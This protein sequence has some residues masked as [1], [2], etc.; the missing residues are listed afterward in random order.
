MI[1]NCQ[2]VSHNQYIR[3]QLSRKK[4]IKIPL[5][6]F[7]V[8]SYYTHKSNIIILIRSKKKQKTDKKQHFLKSLIWFKSCYIFF[9]LLYF[10][11]F[12]LLL[13][14]YI[15][16][17]FLHT[18]SWIRWRMERYIHERKKIFKSPHHLSISLIINI[19]INII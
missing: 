12:L 11:F 3:H 18:F 17:Q 7:L 19:I 15:S 16:I 14:L 2:N 8:M 10:L 1:L 5:K 6:Y 13:M 9:F 4:N